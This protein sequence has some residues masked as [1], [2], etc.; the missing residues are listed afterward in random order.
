MLFNAEAAATL[1]RNLLAVVSLTDPLALKVAENDNAVVAGGVTSTASIASASCCADATY[2]RTG[3]ASLSSEIAT[4]L[5]LGD[6]DPVIVDQDPRL[7]AIRDLGLGALS[8]KAIPF[9][10]LSNDLVRR[11]PGVG[12]PASCKGGPSTELVLR[13]SHAAGAFL[14]LT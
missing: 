8:G 2:A 13:N 11:R 3:L 7:G 10:P 5:V 9:V 12:R 6:Q 14:G 4:C 1:L